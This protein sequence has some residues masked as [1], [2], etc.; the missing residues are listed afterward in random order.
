MIVAFRMLLLGM[1]SYLALKDMDLP[2]WAFI[3]WG[4][5]VVVASFPPV[6]YNETEKR[7]DAINRRFKLW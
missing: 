7:F 6:S 1:L 4:L 2:T 5:V 3:G